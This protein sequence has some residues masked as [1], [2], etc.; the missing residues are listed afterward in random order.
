LKIL[1][2][3]ILVAVLKYSSFI[4]TSVLMAGWVKYSSIQPST[5]LKKVAESSGKDLPVNS[6]LPIPGFNSI[7][8]VS[9]L[10][11]LIKISMVL[12]V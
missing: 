3:T 4:S 11:F 9:K 2:R 10:A 5:G 1:S 6:N 7:A 12:M 8:G